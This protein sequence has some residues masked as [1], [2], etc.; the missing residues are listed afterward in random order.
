MKAASR[1]R[2][3]RLRGAGV[4]A[5]LGPAIGVMVKQT[6]ERRAAPP[7]S[8]ATGEHPDHDRHEDERDRQQN[9]EFRRV[10]TGTSLSRPTPC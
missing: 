9:N 1:P 5:P 4:M 8:R 3:D 6:Q 7:G 2:K 10:P